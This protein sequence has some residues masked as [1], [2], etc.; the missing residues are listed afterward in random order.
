MSE[1]LEERLPVSVRLGASYEDDYAVEIIRTAGDLEYRRL[2]HGLPMRRW[3]VSYTQ[4]QSDIASQL[5]SL[6]HRCYKSY[7]GFRVSCQDDLTTTA[8][9]ISD[10][11]ELDHPL[12]RI[13][14]GVYQLIKRYGVGGSVTSR[15]YPVRT[16]HKP[17]SGSVKIAKNGALVSSGV[18]VDT[19]TGRVTIS[20]APLITDAI[21]GGCRF[22]LPC[23]FDGVLEV[24]SLGGNMRATASVDVV[25]LLA[26]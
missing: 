26:P 10:P 4:R 5:Q 17:V 2:L 24:S 7:A 3:R 16:I 8:D 20:P 14:S 15:G 11:T 25:E 22:D 1:F 9:G 6:Y 23:R 18:V 19:T 12:T 13:S 21:T